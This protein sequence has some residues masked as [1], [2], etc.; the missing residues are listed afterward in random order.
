MVSGF[1]FVLVGLAAVAA[2]VVNALAGGGTLITFPMLI[3]VGIPADSNSEP[4][5]A[6]VSSQS[7][8]RTM[9]VT[10]GKRTVSTASGLSAE[11]GAAGSST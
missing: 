7:P 5:R 10:R 6:V 1:E 9:R 11:N 3:A 4:R 8:D 2:G